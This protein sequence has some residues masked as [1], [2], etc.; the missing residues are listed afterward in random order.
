MGVW[1]EPSPSDWDRWETLI[2]EE[3]SSPSDAAKLLGFG[4]SSAFKRS[5]RE[6]HA[7]VLERWRADRD[8]TDRQTA[9]ETFREVV[10]RSL[11]A[12]P[13]LTK[14]GDHSGEWTYDAPSALRAAE[15]LG[16]SAGMFSDRLEVSGPDG[17]AVKVEIEDRSAS[18]ADIAR[19]LVEAG[20]LLGIPAASSHVPPVGQLLAAPPE[21]ERE[22]SS[23]PDA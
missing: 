6:R 8:E 10:E 14:D 2:F 17:G 23:V 9:R 20:A 7:Q 22:T 13:V 21:G 16:K 1:S 11:V 19:V 15:L 4:G 3:G 18:L 12:T 5:D